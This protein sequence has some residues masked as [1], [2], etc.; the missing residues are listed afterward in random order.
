MW[1]KACAAKAFC[2]VM[3]NQP[4]SPAARATRVPPTKACCMKVVCSTCTQFSWNC[5]AASGVVTRS[6]AGRRG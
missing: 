5:T 6:S 4:I 3:T 2:R 1:A